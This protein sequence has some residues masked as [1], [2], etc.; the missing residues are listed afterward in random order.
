MTRLRK[1]FVIRPEHENWRERVSRNVLYL[2][3]YRE[4]AAGWSQYRM[5]WDREL[6]V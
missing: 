2:A 5:L 6:R 1:R 3:T 4:R